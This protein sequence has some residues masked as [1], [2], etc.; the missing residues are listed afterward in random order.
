M[1]KRNQ[2][3]KKELLETVWHTPHPLKGALLT[4]GLSPLQGVGYARQI[5]N[6]FHIISCLTEFSWKGTIIQFAS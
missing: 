5:R 1:A 6:N 4:L 3:N 2:K